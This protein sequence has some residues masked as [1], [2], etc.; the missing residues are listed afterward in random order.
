[1]VRV[2]SVALTDAIGDDRLLRAGERRVDVL[3]ALRERFVR[4]HASLLFA[5]ERP[6]LVKLKTSDARADDAAIVQFGAA[7]SDTES[8]CA[9]RSTVN[10]REARSGADAE[11]F[12]E[13]RDDFDLLVAREDIHGQHASTKM[14]DV[15]RIDQF[16]L[17]KLK[18]LT[19]TKIIV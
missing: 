11:S 1:M 19:L 13:R 12:G 8:K 5:D 14:A 18:R 3:I 9:D 17:C 4:L 6:H 2:R 15:N 10:A 7:A 16:N